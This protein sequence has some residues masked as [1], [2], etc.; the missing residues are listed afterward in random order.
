M[1]NHI[2]VAVTTL[3][4]GFTACGAEDPDAWSEDWASVAQGVVQTGVTYNL[5]GVHSSK[6]VEIAGGSTSN[7]A[8]VQIATCNGSPRQQFRFESMGGGAYRI[9]NVGSNRCI[10]VEGAS[11]QNAARVLQWECHSNANQQFFANDR[12]N[13]V[14]ELVA[15]HSGQNLD[16]NA[17]GTADGTPLIQWPA[18]GGTNQ[19]FRLTP[20]SGG[21]SGGGSGSGGSSGGGGSDGGDPT[22]CGSGAFHAEAVLN[23][24]SWTV[25]N[26]NNTVWTG[27]NMAEAMRRAL[28]SLSSNRTSK[29]R[30]VVRGSGTISRGE[31]V[32]VPSY[33][34]LDVCGTINVT[35]SS[36]SGDQAPIYARGVHDIEIQNVTITGGPLYSMFFRDVDNLH[37]GNVDIRVTT[38]HG[39]R[40]DNHGRSNRA[41]KVRNIRIDNVYVQ[42]TSLHGVETYGV[43]QLQVGSVIA[44]NTGYSGLLLNDTTNAVVDVVDAQ[45]AG[46]GTGYAA[47]RMANRNGRI[48]GSYPTNIRVGQVIAQGGSRGI[49][50]VSESG[51][52][53]IERVDIANTGN[54]AI[55]VENCYNVNIASVGGT[56]SNSPEIRI[57]SRSEFPVSSGVVFQNLTVTNTNIR[58]SPC[59]TNNSV[60]NNTLIGASLNVCSGTD[61]GGNVRR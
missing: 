18:N 4:L 55:L 2:R 29:Q 5:V 20:V 27:N 48:N 30:V 42:G 8:L 56:V 14:H 11:T 46:T 35:G 16:V 28:G 57:A 22:A 13:T 58:E 45:G 41:N 37:L 24:S 50:C 31:R 12:G 10:D 17:R 40:I 52:A 34:T 26:G 47:F 44:R 19:Q 9:R 39:I 15:R 60:R 6:C 43:D 32:S 25:R 59:G 54:N 33:T 23:G 3:G 51:G 21:G 38:G 7:G 53:V 36:G 1:R 49:F 61:G